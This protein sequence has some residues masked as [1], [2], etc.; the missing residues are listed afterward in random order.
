L[1][2][3]DSDNFV[4]RIFSGLFGYFFGPPVRKG[5]LTGNDSEKILD[6]HFL[7][8]DGPLPPPPKV[9]GIPSPSPPLPDFQEV[10]LYPSKFFGCEGVS[11]QPPSWNQ[12]PVL[13]LIRI[14]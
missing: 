5:R 9:E 3:F 7:S 12:Q 14:M 10:P 11:N 1:E 4:P 8:R 13:D 2:F 6:S